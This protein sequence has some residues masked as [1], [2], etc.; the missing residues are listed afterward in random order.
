[1]VSPRCAYDC[2][3]VRFTERRSSVRRER[4]DIE[5]NTNSTR[6]ESYDSSSTP[7]ETATMKRTSHRTAKRQGFKAL[8]SPERLT[9]GRLHRNAGQDLGDHRRRGEVLEP[10]LRLKNEPV[11]ERRRGERLD[12]VRHHVVAAVH[13]R[14][15]LRRTRQGERTARRG[16]EIHVG[17]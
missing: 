16:A 7:V 2:P 12:V 15:R 9:G 13:R 5:M 11:G 8:L 1:M 10:R 4:T 3:S 14:V 17:V 6:Y